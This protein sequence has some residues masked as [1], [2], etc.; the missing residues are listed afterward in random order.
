MYDRFGRL[1]HGSEV[2]ARDVLEYVVFEK[3]VASTYGVWRIHDKIIPEWM[4]PRQPTNRTYKVKETEE[5]DEAPVTDDSL[6][7]ATTEPENEKNK[8]AVALA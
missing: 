6:Q 5:E 2:V 8:P 4:P 7:D 1:Q 3:H